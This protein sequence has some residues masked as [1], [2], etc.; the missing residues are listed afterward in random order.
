MYN[1][2]LDTFIKVAELGSFSKAAEALYISPSAV[3]QQINNLEANVGAK[4]LKRTQRGVRLTDAGEILYRDG[5]E[6]INSSRRILEQI[7]SLQEEKKSELCIG[8]TPLEQCRMF[9]KLWRDFS[10]NEKNYHV[11]IKTLHDMENT[12]EMEDVDLIEGVYIGSRYQ[13]SLNFVQLT[14]IPIVHAVWKEHPLA[15][16]E[17]LRYEDMAGQTMITLTDN[18][19]IE[20]VGRLKEEAEKYGIN[21]IMMRKYE[22]SVFS[23]CITNGY[24]MQMPLCGKDVNSE[25]VA[26]PCGWDYSLPYGFYYKKNPSGAVKKFIEYVKE[27]GKLKTYSYE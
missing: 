7:H 1:R 18:D 15:Q 9:Y 16:K 17:I 5:Q 12:E 21:I 14:S 24:V 25:I 22:L 10:A 27:Q 6:L 19:H 26:I 3:V 8:T 4:L 11:R 13:K 2:Q 20:Q 23:T